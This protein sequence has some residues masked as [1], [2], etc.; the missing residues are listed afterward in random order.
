MLVALTAHQ[1]S[2]SFADL[3]RLSVLG[4][5][6]ASELTSAHDTIRGAVV[7]GTRYYQAWYRD[8]APFCTP[9]FYNMTNAVQITWGP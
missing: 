5:T 1:R 9:A 8:S 6:V 7:P 2:T 4:D 3:E